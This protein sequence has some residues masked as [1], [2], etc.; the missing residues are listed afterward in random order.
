LVYLASLRNPNS[1]LYEHHGLALVFDE[2][3]AHRALKK[4]HSLIFREWLTFNLA[5][6]KADIDLYLSGLSEDK[7]TVLANWLDLSPYRSLIPTSI[8]PVDRRLYLADLRAL[9]DLLG[10]EYGVVGP[11]PTA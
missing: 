3:E 7:R 6:Q 10:N 11:G 1:G 8:R 9:I 4:S 5:Q 2:D